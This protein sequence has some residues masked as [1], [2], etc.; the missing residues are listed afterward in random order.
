MIKQFAICNMNVD[1]HIQSCYINI[2]YCEYYI[3]NNVNID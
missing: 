2:A 1:F 3:G